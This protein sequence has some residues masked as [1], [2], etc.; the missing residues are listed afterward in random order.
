[1]NTYST[2]SFSYHDLQNIID[3]I[4]GKIGLSNTIVLLEQVI[5]E[6]SVSIAGGE[7]NKLISAY[8]VSRCLTTFDLIDSEFNHSTVREYREARMACFHL[9]KKYTEAS[10]AYIAQ[11][12]DQKKRNVLY[13]CQK[14]DDMLSV[15]QFHRS[16]IERYQALE[17]NI[18]EFI[19]KLNTKSTS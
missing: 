3:R 12:F 2:Q 11:Q 15:P 7:K 16:F 19:P 8:L 9:L 4:I 14:C 13:S 17:R 1:M 10:Y 5:Q 18:L 6:G